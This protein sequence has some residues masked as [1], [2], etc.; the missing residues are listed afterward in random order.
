MDK[1][2]V[3]TKLPPREVKPREPYRPPSKQTRIEDSRGVVRLDYVISLRDS[4]LDSTLSPERQFRLLQ[5]AD[6]MH[7]S[8][9]IMEE[10]EISRAVNKLKK[11]EDPEVKSL[12]E[13]I[14]EK[15]KKLALDGFKHR[16]RRVEKGLAEHKPFPSS[17]RSN[18]VVRETETF[19]EKLEEV[20]VANAEGEINRLAAARKRQRESVSV[21]C[22]KEITLSSSPLQLKHRENTVGGLVDRCVKKPLVLASVQ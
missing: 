20:E 2:I 6:A 9:E 19:C 13:T 7:C 8:L 4:I 14:V 11:S 3:R 16:S 18:R 1:F 21:F 5:E 15:W 22:A 10:T 12:A 17:K